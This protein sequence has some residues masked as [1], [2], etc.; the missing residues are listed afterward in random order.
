MPVSNVISLPTRPEHRP[1]ELEFD[2]DM[3][4]CLVK[5]TLDE[6]REVLARISP[7]RVGKTFRFTRGDLTLDVQLSAEGADVWRDELTL[8]LNHFAKR[9]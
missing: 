6:A 9:R 4:V 3:L 5:L 2:N 8:Q 1:V 7:W